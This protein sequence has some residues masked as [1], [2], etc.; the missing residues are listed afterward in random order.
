MHVPRV[1]DGFGG[2]VAVKLSYA[3]VHVD[4][5][6]GCHMAEEVGVQN[7]ICELQLLL[8]NFAKIRVLPLSVT[9][10]TCEL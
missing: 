10:V 5:D 9:P 6:V 8:L 3:A 2:V 4:A 7:H 1:A